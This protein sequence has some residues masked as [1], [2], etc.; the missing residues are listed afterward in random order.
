MSLLV[1]AATSW[2]LVESP[3]AKTAPRFA[4]GRHVLV[5]LARGPILESD[6]SQGIDAAT[7]AA[8]QAPN[9]NLHLNLLNGTQSPSSPAP[10]GLENFS[11]RLD[12][13]SL[14]F[15]QNG[16][17]VLALSSAGSISLS[18][19]LP[20]PV[21]SR[22]TWSGVDCLLWFDG[23]FRD[24]A[25]GEPTDVIAFY[26]PASR[27]RIFFR[28][29]SENFAVERTY[30]AL[31]QASSLDHIALSQNR[32]VL[33]V[34]A[35]DQTTS[36]VVS[37]RYPLRFA[38]SMT[39]GASIRSGEDKQVIVVTDPSADSMTVGA[40]IISGIDFSPLVSPDPSADSMQV[41]ALLLSGAD[42]LVLTSPDPSA[43]SMTIG[44]S[45]LNGLDS[46]VLVTS[47]PLADS[48]TVGV[49]LIS[50]SIA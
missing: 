41:A 45:I 31:S 11:D 24:V 14:S 44:A 47:D 22:V 46:L 32:L 48:M 30:V 27:D 16:R 5:S 20:G 38:D 37:D 43:D 19:L 36:S 50:G 42:V 25:G 29:Q 49:S 35:K 13:I 9:K 17:R 1:F 28:I 18:R 4:G 21:E 8:W 40:S 33:Y 3:K 7:W 2:V 39:V 15:D 12:R 6:T 10:F 23:L 34:T 26:L